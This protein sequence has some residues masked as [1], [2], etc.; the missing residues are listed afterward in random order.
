MFSKN[1]LGNKTNSQLRK[2][3]GK[4]FPAQKT[5]RVEENVA[6]RM[7]TKRKTYPASEQ[8]KIQIKRGDTVEFGE[9]GQIKKCQLGKVS[10][11][12]YWKIPIRGGG[13]ARVDFPI[14][15]KTCAKNT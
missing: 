8:V 1:N 7:Y 9:E 12:K 13:S 11:K 6:K 10:K 4:K 5:A 14:R 15:K 2:I 3:V